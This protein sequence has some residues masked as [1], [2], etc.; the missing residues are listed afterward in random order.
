VNNRIC[1]FKSVQLRTREVPDGHGGAMV[2]RKEYDLAGARE[3]RLEL[4][5]GQILSDRAWVVN[6]FWAAM[7][8]SIFFALIYGVLVVG[9]RLDFS[10]GS[11]KIYRALYIGFFLVSFLAAWTA[12]SVP[13]AV[14]GLKRRHVEAERGEGN[15]ILVDLDRWDRFHRILTAP[16]KEIKE[17]RRVPGR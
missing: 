4:T 13:G 15:W 2:L 8:V 3:H 6:L 11:G 12:L 9:F 5:P 14:K 17:E 1:E 16:K 7:G 10:S